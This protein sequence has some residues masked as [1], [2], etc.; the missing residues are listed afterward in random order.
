MKIIEILYL[1]IIITVGGSQLC[2]CLTPISE[3][4]KCEVDC[5]TDCNDITRVGNKCFSEFACD[6]LL[7][8]IGK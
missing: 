5:Q 1:K 4:D 2:D 7:F 8:D 3:C 6:D